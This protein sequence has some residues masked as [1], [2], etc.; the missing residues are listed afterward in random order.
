MMIKLP[1][2]PVRVPSMEVAIRLPRLLV[3]ISRSSGEEVISKFESLELKSFMA[4]RRRIR[5]P[6]AITPTSLRTW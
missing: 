5:S 4:L 2:R 1:P 6:A 3:T